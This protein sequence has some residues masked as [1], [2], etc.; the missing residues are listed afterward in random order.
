MP[1][2]D[3]GI[4]ISLQLGSTRSGRTWTATPGSLKNLTKARKMARTI[5][6]PKLLL[7]DDL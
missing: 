6:A 7:T 1:D 3:P 2:K 5:E 4:A